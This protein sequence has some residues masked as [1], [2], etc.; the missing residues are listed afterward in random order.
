MLEWLLRQIHAS[1]QIRA[2]FDQATLEVQRP[3]LLWEGLA[4]A[5][6]I[7][8]FVYRRQR[9][10]LS[11]VSPRLRATLTV[12]RI[13]I[14]LLLVLVVAAPYLKLDMKIE[15]KPIVALLFDQ[16]QSMG[17]PVGS[18]D[19]D[20]LA[21]TAQSIGLTLSD[22]KATPETRAVTFTVSPSAVNSGEEAE[23]I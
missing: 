3:G 11:T 9:E 10:S 18:L 13:L 7:A 16:S 6:P 20:E 14:L 8:W 1:D 22:G 4:L 21:N 2:H 15:K 23:G 12:T 17:L 19:G 5:V